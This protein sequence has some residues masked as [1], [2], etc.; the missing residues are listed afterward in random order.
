MG[1]LIDRG[2]VD[3]ED[4]KGRTVR[5]PVAAGLFYPADPV[6]LRSRILE[7]LEGPSRLEK[8]SI[9]SVI[10]P[11][12]GYSYSGS[13]AALAYREIRKGSFKRVIVI[14]PS[15]RDL[16]D[17]VSVYSGD[18]YQSPLGGIAVDGDFCE[19]LAEKCDVAWISDKGHSVSSGSNV[20][21]H[22]LEVQLP[23]LQCALDEFSLVPLVMGQQDLGTSASL[24]LAL[25][26]LCDDGKTLIVASSDLSHFHSYE[27]ARSMD[28][29]FLDFL[30]RF[31]YFSLSHLME[32]GEIEACGGGPVMAALIA[33]ENM[34]A[35][36]CEILEYKNSGDVE[37]GTSDRVVGYASAVLLE[38]S[39]KRTESG[40][41]DF[42]EEEKEFLLELSRV[43]VECAVK[44]GENSLLKE[45]MPERFLQKAAAFVTRTEHGD[46]RGCI[47]SIVPQDMLYRTVAS[48]AVN[49][50]LHD[51]RFNPVTEKDLHHLSYEISVLSRFK[52]V[53]DMEEIQIGRHGLLIQSGYSKGLLLPQ[54]ATEHS[55]DRH[56]F[57]EQT[58]IK[59]SLP[60][61]AWK[62]PSTDLFLFSAEVFN[63]R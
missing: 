1:G 14:S 16:F 15:H 17:G 11:H 55:W 31:D 52:L 51:P 7:L 10:V 8:Q 23:F 20:G 44:G 19:L 46:L 5:E 63:S 49:A 6:L 56:T 34:G 54:V 32:V 22:A 40:A 33:S 35:G 43:S 9:R 28:L 38:T 30:R 60:R 27:K 59:A 12:A 37:S 36:V 47:G 13:V 24:G 21:E 45:R 58:C 53:A 18:I 3:M 42:S 25:S 61:D 39:E 4:V 2:W 26:D 57:L 62:K 29:K 41:S 48:S 50:A